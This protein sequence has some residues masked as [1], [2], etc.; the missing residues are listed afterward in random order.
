[1]LLG[2][3]LLRRSGTAFGIGNDLHAQALVSQSRT[4][5]DALLFA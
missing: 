3:G 4:Q 2:A 1:M 5:D